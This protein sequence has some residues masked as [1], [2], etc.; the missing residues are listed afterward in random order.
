MLCVSVGD[1]CLCVFT[2]GCGLCALCVDLCSSML[3]DMN[4]C[5][6]DMLCYVLCADICV[7][8]CL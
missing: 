5:V 1:M 6:W 2:S 8:L 7:F 4:A 3:Y